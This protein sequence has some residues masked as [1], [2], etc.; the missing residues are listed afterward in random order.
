M[1]LENQKRVK[2]FAEQY[3]PEN[4]VV[5]LGAAEGEAAGLAAET[6]TAGDPTYA[7]PLAG[8]QLGL[9]VFHVCENEIKDEVDSSVYDDQISM[10]EMVMDVDDIAKEMSSIREQYC[11]YL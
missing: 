6:V 1:D 10:M 3:G 9:S 5:V 2:D 7:G 11:K 4:I 8:V